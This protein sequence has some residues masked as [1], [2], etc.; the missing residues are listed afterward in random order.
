VPT[1]RGPTQLLLN[2]DRN[3]LFVLCTFDDSI[4][5]FDAESLE[6]VRTIR[7]G[8]IVPVK[9]F[10]QSGEELFYD[11]RL[12]LDGW[13]SCHS[14]H[15]DGHSTGQLN[16]NFGD[17]SFGTPKRIL[18]LLG[19]G[20]TEPWA[21]NGSLIDLRNQIRKSIHLT[22]AGPGKQ[23]PTI[24]EREIESLDSFLS[25]LPPAPGIL[26][27]RDEADRPSIRRGQ[28]VFASHGCTGCHQPPSFASPLS[29]DVGFRDEAGKRYFN[30]PSLMGV[31]QRGPYFHDNRAARLVD[32]L[33]EFDHADAASLPDTEID[34]LVD[35][36]KSL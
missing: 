6:L 27:A 32:V 10:M 11:S 2:E 12:S 16:D 18:T 3:R 33:L 29:F 7:L 19:T 1:G 28:Q 22:M 30:P 34:D 36:L 35:F 23:S 26:T 15:S 5:E 14:C 31:S 13:F 20:D 9:S 21:W 4:A 24:G 17:E 25:S 8:P